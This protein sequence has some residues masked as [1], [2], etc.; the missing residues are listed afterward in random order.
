VFKTVLLA[1]QQIRVTSSHGSIF[2]VTA[3]AVSQSGGNWLSVSPTGTTGQPITV[4]VNPGSIPPGTYAGQITVTSPSAAN[5]AQAT[6]GSNS[7]SGRATW[8]N[9][10][11]ND[12]LPT[13]LLDVQV[14]VNNQSAYI[15]FVNDKQINT[16]VPAMNG[17]GTVQVEGGTK[18]GTTSTAISMKSYSPAFFPQY[19]GSKAYAT[20]V[21]VGESTTTLAAPAGAALG[22]RTR[23]EAAAL[24][25]A[26]V[27]RS[28]PLLRAHIL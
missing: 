7:A 3:T 19:V 9:F 14:K 16:I 11:V 26:Q 2:A 15:Y 1:A 5:Q 8:E 17:T 22:N 24:R 18:V 10:I 12:Q 25:T 13:Q 27:L 28:A 23:P 4:S 6:V 20:A 21:I